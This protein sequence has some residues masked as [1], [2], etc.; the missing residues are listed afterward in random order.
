[1]EVEVTGLKVRG[2][3]HTMYDYVWRLAAVAGTRS[4]PGTRARQRMMQRSREILASGCLTPVVVELSDS[5]LA[6][7]LRMLGY[8]HSN[9]AGCML[10]GWDTEAPGYHRRVNTMASAVTH[11]NTLTS[12]EERL[13]ENVHSRCS[14]LVRYRGKS[15]EVF[16]IGNES[17]SH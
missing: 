7:V 12:D 9:D 6:I 5:T 1:M 10:G 2:I 13:L 3:S 15:L 8:W 14:N 4:V 17:H 11:G 16:L